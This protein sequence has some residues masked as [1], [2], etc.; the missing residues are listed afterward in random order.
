MG[1]RARPKF[2]PTAEY[3][4]SGK[5]MLFGGVDF[6]PGQDFNIKTTPRQ[7][8]ILYES[9][10][11]VMKNPPPARVHHSQRYQERQ[12][13]VAAKTDQQAA[14]DAY[15]QSHNND[16]VVPPKTNTDTI[17]PAK[18]LALVEVAT[19]WWNVVDQDGNQVNDKKLRRKAAEELVAAG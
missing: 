2:D 3:V 10:H 11:L 6:K 15:S 8:R 13:A 18:T 16:P 14:M 17:A 4:V 5:G 7:M 1:Y 19:G 9:R 12:K